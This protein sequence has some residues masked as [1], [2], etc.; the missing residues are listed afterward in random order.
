[1]PAQNDPSIID[2]GFEKYFSVP[3]LIAY[4]PLLAITVALCFDVGFFYS[5]DIGLFTLFSLSEHILFALEALPVAMVILFMIA[6]MLV[7]LSQSRKTSKT[8]SPHLNKY[9]KIAA[10]SVLAILV[11]SMIGFAAY[12]I[13][14]SWKATPIVPFIL[15]MTIPPVLA[16]VIV[17]SRL[18]KVQIAATAILICIVLSFSFGFAFGAGVV[19]RPAVNVIKLKNSQ[20]PLGGLIM[21]SGERGVLL[22]HHAS[23]SIRFQPWEAIG[24]IETS[25]QVGNGVRK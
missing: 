8:S 7:P 17:D 13:Y 25:V 3:N 18:K 4:I 5:F 20:V 2:A 6:I 16:S 19:N 22:Y 9:Q 11:G 24:S 23:K 15:V 10:L 12:I 14:E 1:M 21:R